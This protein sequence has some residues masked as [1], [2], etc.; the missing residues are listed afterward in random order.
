MPTKEIRIEFPSALVRKPLTQ[1][2]IRSFPS[3][4]INIHMAQISSNGGWMEVSISG[5]SLEIDNA[6]DWIDKQGL[7]I[8][9]AG[10][11]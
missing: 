2:L 11:Q 5:K 4:I 8:Q 3:L 9:Q 10:G 6:L 7:K 1:E